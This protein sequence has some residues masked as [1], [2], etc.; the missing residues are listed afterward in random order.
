VQLEIVATGNA[1]EGKVH[2]ICM[3]LTNV[4]RVKRELRRLVSTGHV[5]FFAVVED[6]GTCLRGTL[7]SS[8]HVLTIAE[9]SLLSSASCTTSNV[10]ILASGLSAQDS[11]VSCLISGFRREVY[12]NALFLDVTQH[13]MVISYRRFG[14][15][16]QS[17]LQNQEFLTLEDGTDSLSLNV[18]KELPL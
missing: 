10:S 8:S 13:I 2:D 9:I 5:V 18:D 17:R 11:P 15:M 3:K 7:L 4:T 6:A 14:T 12:E 1:T 16:Y